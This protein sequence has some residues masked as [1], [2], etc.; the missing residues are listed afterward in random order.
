MILFRF[1]YLPQITTLIT[2][3]FLHLLIHLFALC[4]TRS[5]ALLF[6]LPLSLA[7][8]IPSSITHSFIHSQLAHSLAYSLVC[9]VAYFLLIHLLVL[10]RASQLNE[11]LFTRSLAVSIPLITQMLNRLLPT[12]PPP[13]HVLYS[14]IRPFTCLLP[15]SLPHSFFIHPLACL[16]VPYRHPSLVTALSCSLVSSFPP[17]FIDA[18]VRLLTLLLTHSVAFSLFF[19]IH[20]LA[21][22][23]HSFFAH[24]LPC[25]RVLSLTRS[26]PCF[27]P[28]LLH[29][30]MCSLARSLTNSL[31][32]LH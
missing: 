21:R 20:L 28:F 18:L 5:L 29:S 6:D 26:L 11:L 16:L 32:R 4:L 13:P 10:S 25:L 8:F 17:S 15:P 24:S 1:L 23:L 27:F 12:P 19:L 14:L 22:V 2:C 31:A 30:L 7:R 9:S 3:F